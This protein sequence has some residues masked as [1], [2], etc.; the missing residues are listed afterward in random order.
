MTHFHKNYNIDTGLLG[1]DESR[2]VFGMFS[3]LKNWFSKDQENMRSMEDIKGDIQEESVR[4]SNSQAEG[5]NQQKQRVIESK[6]VHTELSLHE[7]WE[8]HLDTEKKYTLRFLQ[9]ELPDMDEGT[10]G[11]TG[12]SLVP[13]DAGVTATVFFRNA[14]HLPLRFETIGL[15][16]YGGKEVIAKGRFDLSEIGAIPPYTSRPWEVFFPLETYEQTNTLFDRWK[17]VMDFGK[18]IIVWP[19]HLDLDPAM[20][21][22]M[23]EA[24][25][26]RLYEIVDRLPAI[27]ENHVEINGFDIGKTPD[28]K[29]VIGLLFRNAMHR[30]YNPQKLT[31]RVT[32]Y[33]GELIASGTIDA[34]NIKVRPGTSRPWLVVFPADRVKKP[35]F[36]PG[37][38]LLKVTE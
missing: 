36:E 2:G 35:D 31:L 3:F 33:E 18:Q 11:I 38:W 23:T 32:T 24:Q 34:S 17:I 29:L 14:T 21:E 22:R 1:L 20:E 28:G 37:K 10:I 26:E 25:K 6:K 27:A 19:K 30:E 16:I 13:S 8:R 5:N 9:A 4:G 15:T 12:F 7:G